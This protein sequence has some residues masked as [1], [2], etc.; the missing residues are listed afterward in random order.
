MRRRFPE[1]FYDPDIKKMWETAIFVPDTNVLL[2][3]F[4]FPPASSKGLLKILKHL[5]GR[6]RLWIP[7]QFAY[8]YVRK[9]PSIRRDIKGD[10]KKRMQDLN[11]WSDNVVNK[12]REFDDLNRLRIR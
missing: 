5:K 8:E 7:Y 12:L 2:D 6:N 11:Q 9:Q 3:I 1:Y 10:D 4:R